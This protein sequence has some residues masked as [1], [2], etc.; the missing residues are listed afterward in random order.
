MKKYVMGLLIGMIGLTA[1]GDD[2]QP[3]T[4]ALNKLTKVSCY[5]EGD[6]TPLFEADI[7]Y[8]SDG[9]I[10]SINYDGDRWL[11]I[12]VD[13]KLS[14]TKVSSDS[15]VD[16][17]TLSGG[18][19]TGH[20]VSRENPGASNEIYTSD[21]YTYRYSGS[22]WIQT[23]WQTRWP[24]ETGSGYEERDYPEYER[25][26]WENGNAV[27]YAQ[28]LDNREMRYEYGM[29]L[30]PANFPLRVIGSF[31]PVDFDAVSP[32]NLLHGA[33]NRN[34]PT[35]AYTYSILDPGVTLSEYT[36]SYTTVGDYVTAMTIQESG[37]GQ[38][39]LYRYTFEYNFEAR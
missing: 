25:Y 33:S 31:S 13:D 29:E 26:T 2:D 30:A 7:H 15:L 18:V 37:E 9:K 22:E 14:V 17:Y 6:A 20:K 16:E 24:S 4:P 1:C 32:L 3:L 23:S 28:S 19:I 34:L 21:T 12:Y 27:L 8:T 39:S 35:R 11:F 36:Y 5:K 38:T 10:S